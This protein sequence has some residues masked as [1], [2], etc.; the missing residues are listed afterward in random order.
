MIVV[1]CLALVG[2]LLAWG[3]AAS[4]K[5]DVDNA[6]LK[7]TCGANVLFLGAAGS[8]EVKDDN[9]YLGFGATV[10]ESYRAMSRSFRPLNVVAE[11]VNYAAMSV[12]QI[13][14]NIGLGVNDYTAS[15]SAGFESLR[16]QLGGWH[17]KCR[18]YRFVL[19]GY[20][21][22]ADVVADVLADLTVSTRARDREILS[23]VV[24]VALFGDP[25]FN[26]ADPSNVHQPPG[27]GKGAFAFPVVDRLGGI[28]PVW[29]E[30]IR[31]RVGSWCLPGD[32]VCNSNSPDDLLKLAKVA[33]G[34]DTPHY[35]YV[36]SGLSSEAGNWLADKARN[37]LMP[38][39]STGPLPVITPMASSPA[40]PAPSTLSA[41]ASSPA[42]SSI[43]VPTKPGAATAT[44]AVDVPAPGDGQIPPATD[45]GQEPLPVGASE[46]G[47]V[48]IERYC[49]Q[50]WGYHA[51]LRFPV[52]WGWRCAPRRTEAE[53]NRVGDQNVDL[54]RAC[55]QQYIEGARSRYRQYQDPS[56]WFC[57]VA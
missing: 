39:A 38:P 28:R 57:W 25:Q 47:G 22:G 42:R 37:A 35:H 44:S 23:A 17:D 33:I 43:R 9:P 14:K 7:D 48:D 1:T 20:S 5:T 45:P 41:V 53:G 29:P 52:A 31:A 2:G 15:E 8:G 27:S 16:L 32:L 55:A 6:S 36:S 40:P 13:F 11:P 26:P 18:D 46:R 24:G 30:A 54:D 51:V 10:Y 56:S 12:P 50:G 21:Q 3:I 34:G 19:A 49:S 4:S